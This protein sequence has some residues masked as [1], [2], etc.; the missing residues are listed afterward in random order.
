MNKVE[1]YLE[2]VKKHKEA[3]SNLVEPEPPRIELEDKIFKAEPDVFK[4]DSF[5]NLDILAPRKSITLT[6]DESIKVAKW[7]LD[8]FQEKTN[9]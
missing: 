9:D 6:P 4:V 1:K 2:D 3:L 5:G 8:I 7:I